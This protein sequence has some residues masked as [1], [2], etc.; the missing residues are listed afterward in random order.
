MKCMTISC[1]KSY[2]YFIGYWILSIL[3]SIITAY[4]DS[5][6]KEHPEYNKNI[7]LTNQLIFFISQIGGDLLAGFLVLYT[8]ITTSTVLINEKENNI[9]NE[10]SNEFCK[11]I[12]RCSLIIIVSIIEF[13]C[14]IIRPIFALYYKK[15]EVGEIMTFIYI[16]VLSRIFFSYYM[17]KNT[18]YKHHIVSLII[19]SIGY[20]IKVIL[21]FSIGDLDLE[22]WPYF[23]AF[24]IQLILMGLEDILNKLLLTEKYMLPH[25]LMFL[26]GVYNS[27]MAIV[28]AIIIIFSG[29][30]FTVSSYNNIFLT[31][32]LLIFFFLF[33]NF[34]NIFIN[35]TFTPHH[36]SFL[37]LVFYMLLLLLYRIVSNQ[38]ALLIVSEQIIYLFMIFSTLLFN[39]MIIINKCGL[40]K[41][42]RKQTLIKLQHEFDDNRDTELMNE[43]QETE[44]LNLD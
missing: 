44:K 20:F 18:L 31:F 40:N 42:T 34:F 22:K 17:L 41:N 19:F 33:F 7:E 28:L 1:Y 43:Q 2:Y 4:I 3:F 9:N 5:Q 37:N 25:V 27:G 15:L 23:I 13:A 36:L 10:N 38:S 21:A 35:F 11:R 16:I 26:R 14:R 6:E 24:V 12:S 29:F 8:Y 32:S 39:E 30:E